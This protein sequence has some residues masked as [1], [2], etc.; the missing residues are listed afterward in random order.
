MMLIKFAIDTHQDKI[1]I[2]F[3]TELQ[4]DIQDKSYYFMTY[5]SKCIAI[6]MD[7]RV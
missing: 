2:S 5:I 3:F 1:L 4:K 7:I 6:Y